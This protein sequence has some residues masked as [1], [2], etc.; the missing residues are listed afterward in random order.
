MI[1]RAPAASGAKAAGGASG[2]TGIAQEDFEQATADR[3]AY[4]GDLDRVTLTGVA[5]QLFLFHFL[6]VVELWLVSVTVG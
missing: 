4:D 5:G 2:R 1:R 6:G 3:A